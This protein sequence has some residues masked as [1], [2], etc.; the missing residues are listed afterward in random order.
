M[1]IHISITGGERLKEALNKVA[2]TDLMVKAGVPE[3]ATTTDGMSIAKYAYWN[4][5]G[6]PDNNLPARPF[7]RQTVND[8]QDKWKGLLQSNLSFMSLTQ[9]N[10]EAVMGLLGEVMVA[11][12]K[13][14]IQRGNFAA[15]SPATVASKRRKGK[16]EPDH[17]LIDTEQM[18]ESIISEVVKP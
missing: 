16:K 13:K 18:L 5:V 14:T 11:D 6:Y 7:L 10:G 12:I 4:E 17:P 9:D 3:G 15:D 1:K 8:N 2:E